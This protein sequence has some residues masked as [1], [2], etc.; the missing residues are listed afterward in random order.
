ML[1]H[2]EK[3]HP[4]LRD[5]QQRYETL[6]ES[7]GQ[8]LVRAHTAR[9]DRELEVAKLHE[10]VDALEGAIKEY[11]STP[12]VILDRQTLRDALAAIEKG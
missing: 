7:T 12:T 9:G 6:Q 1:D 8:A 3:M 5:L 4:D 11:L 10:R 2:I